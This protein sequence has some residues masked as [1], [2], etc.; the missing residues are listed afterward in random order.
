MARSNAGGV[1]NRTKIAVTSF[2][3]P[4]GVQTG[5]TATFILKFDH[6][7]SSGVDITDFSS[8]KTGINVTAATAKSGDA[9]TYNVVVDIPFGT[10]DARLTFA[11]N[12]IPETDNYLQ[13]PD[14]NFQSTTIS[15]NRQPIVALPFWLA[16]A[17]SIAADTATA[18]GLL[19]FIG[20]AVS[21]IES[22][23]FA[24]INDSGIEQTGW[25][26]TVDR[27]SAAEFENINVQATRTTQD[28][29]G[30]FKLRLKANSVISAP[31]TSPNVP[32]T[33]LDS[34]SITI[35][36][37]PVDQRRAASLD[38]QNTFTLTIPL[39]ANKSG[40][41]QISVNPDS[42]YVTGNQSR[43]GPEYQQYLGTIFY[44]TRNKVRFIIGLAYDTLQG[45]GI[46]TEINKDTYIEIRAVD[47]STGSAV[48]VNDLTDSDILVTGAC[49]GDLYSKDGATPANSAWRLHIDPHENI[50][51]VFTVAIPENIVDAGNDAIEKSYTYDTR[52]EE[53]IAEIE[54]SPYLVLENLPTDEQNGLTFDFNYI[55]MLGATEIDAE[56]L[57]PEDFIIT[58][59]DG[60]AR[61][62]EFNGTPIP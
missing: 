30:T 1:D 9:T 14:N 19:S 52:T 24:I 45:S 21:G 13:G 10:G 22:S 51:G 40:A 47:A 62:S 4:T 42:F 49:K 15:Y 56:N 20:N 60:T 43:R 17:G 32:G 12:S 36:N 59:P 37:R 39:P 8:N 41:M 16:T 18:R 38:N 48:A 54:Q 25:T 27:S 6:A 44:D 31:S 11:A 55:G 35:D 61:I 57:G 2:T 34:P 26:I 50:D 53:E 33:A 7:V 28:V 58:S 29:N 5:A 23:D 46:N 3:A